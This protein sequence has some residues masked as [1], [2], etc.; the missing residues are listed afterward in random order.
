MFIK[1][2]NKQTTCRFTK[3]DK[4][5]KQSVLIYIQT[6]I[7]TSTE[8]INVSRDGCILGV[9]YMC[10]IRVIEITVAWQ[11]AKP[12]SCKMHTFLKNAIIFTLLDSGFVWTNIKAFYIVY[13]NS[14]V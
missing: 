7:Q 4:N 11:N 8:Q 14:A 3:R 6:Y 12:V 5:F 9:L 13:K 1:I 2:K 10:T